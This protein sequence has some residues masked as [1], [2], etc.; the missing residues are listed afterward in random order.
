MSHHAETPSADDLMTLFLCGDVMTGRGIDQILPQPGDPCLHEPYIRDARDYW[1]LAEVANGPV[2]RPVAEEYIWGDALEEWN[3]VRPD[4][5]IVNLETAVT[6]SDD[7]WQG[8]EVHY[9]MSPRNVGCLKAG[10]I[11]CCTLANN[12]VLDWGYPG[13]TETL[14]TLQQAGFKTAGAGQ[15]Q[16]EAEAPVTLDLGNK[17]RVVVFACGSETSGIPS[18]WAAADGRPGV[19]LLPDMSDATVDRIHSAIARHRRDSDVII[20]SVH[21]GSN[22][23]YTV[24]LAERSFAQKLIDHAGVDVVHGHSSHHVKG[25]EVYRN[26]LILYG[27]GDFVT[28]YEGIRG[29]ESFRGDLALMYFA[30][31]EAS[32]GRLVRLRMTPLQVHRMRLRRAS[33]ADADWLREVLDRQGNPLGTHVYLAE[34]GT[35]TLQWS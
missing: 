20:A 19:N 30:S 12:H 26:R 13:L 24:T 7:Y 4:V 35:L 23:G 18:E 6:T 22:W 21:W 33:A 32:S 1:R 5:R 11:D 28:D 15:S 3:R 31:V 34:E 16:A 10:R 2:P 25:I 14:R 29:Y 27:C 17:G 8:K 9:R